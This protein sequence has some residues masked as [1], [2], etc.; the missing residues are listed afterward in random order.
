M[1]LSIKFMLVKISNRE[2]I[3]NCK[4]IS[5]EIKIKNQL[6]IILL[7]LIINRLIKF[8]KT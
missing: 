7:R 5:R 1:K 6:M 4:I 3:Y 8:Y 2:E